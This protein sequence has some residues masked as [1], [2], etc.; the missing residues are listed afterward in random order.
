[1][2]ARSRP[3]AHELGPP[4]HGGLHHPLYQRRTVQWRL[5][6]GHQVRVGDPQGHT[7]AA[8]GTVVGDLRRGRVNLEPPP[9]A[10]VESV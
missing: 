7:H 2:F 9:A 6:P 4:D 5:Q 1:M 8:A 10:V 3:H